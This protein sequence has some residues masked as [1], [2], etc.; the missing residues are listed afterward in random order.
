MDITR[1][2]VDAIEGIGPS[3]KAA[4][5][6]G[7][8]HCVSDLLIHAPDFLHALV[9]H[10]SSHEQVSQW[11]TM[12]LF[13]QAESMTAQWAEALARQ[14]VDGFER[15]LELELDELAQC[16][17]AAVAQ[18]IIST[19]PTTSGLFTLSREICRL[20]Y[21][22]KAQGFLRGEGGAPVADAE[23]RIGRHAV[24]SN[25]QG[26][27][28][29]NG[30][31]AGYPQMLTVIADGYADLI[32]QDVPLSTDD[33]AMAPQHYE[34]QA[35]ASL[36]T[37]WDEY[38]GAA[39]PSISSC[40]PEVERHDQSELREDD[41]LVVHELYSRSEHVRL[42][43]IFR[44]WSRG[45]LI[46]RAYKVALASLPGP[47]EPGRYY[48]WR[49]GAFAPRNLTSYNVDGARARRRK[50]VALGGEQAFEGLSLIETLQRY[51]GPPG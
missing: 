50:I 16:F 11:R 29:A 5:A 6:G 36:P 40:V 33:W 3:I 34:L 24:L 8:I 22:A 46:V 18:A 25:A 2:P 41:V 43:S 49:R 1:T 30:I 38:E 4:L 21:G 39:L 47:V 15:F 42:V 45:R 31:D 48:E 37:I 26:Y 23:V 44:A 13:L 12:A 20:H 14:N 51:L 10:A 9:A 7:G 32:V 19:P 17:D 35:G 28:Q 27:W